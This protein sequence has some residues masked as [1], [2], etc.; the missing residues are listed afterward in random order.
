[1]TTNTE[2]TPAY[3]ARCPN[4]G[5]VIGAAVSDG[6]H[7]EDTANTLADWVRDGLVIERT[8][9]GEARQVFDRCT[10]EKEAS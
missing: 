1:M 6:E 8:T 4:C 2:T 3:T 7:L 5:V 9:V 10:C